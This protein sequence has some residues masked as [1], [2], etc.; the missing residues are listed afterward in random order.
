MESKKRAP[1]ASKPEQLPGLQNGRSRLGQ[2]LSEFAL[3]LPILLLMIF[4][5]IEFAR[6]FQAYLVI[7]NASRFGVRY[8]V[9]GEYDPV[10]CTDGPDSGS[11]AC[12][13]PG[14]TAEEDQARL[15]SIYDVVNGSAVAILKDLGVTD[16]ATAGYFHVTVCSSRPGFN[17]DAASDHCNPMDDPGNPEEGPTRVMVAVTFQ[18][19]MILPFLTT[20]WPTTRLHSERTGILEQFRVARVLGLPPIID[21]PTPT[22]EPPTLTPTFTMT[23]SPTVTPTPTE[24]STP[25]PTFTPTPTSTFTPT[26]VPDC[27]DLQTDSDEPLYLNADDLGIWL[28]NNN[29]VYPAVMTSITT[30]WGGGWHDQVDPVPVNQS[31]DKYTWKGASISNPANVLLT[32]GGSFTHTNLGTIPVSTEGVLGMDFTSSFANVYAYYHGADFS[33][34]LAYTLGGLTCSK[35]VVG[36]LG[37]IVSLEMPPD[38]ITGPFTIRAQASDPDGTVNRVVFEIRDA[39]NNVVFQ[40]TENSAPYCINGDGG[41]GCALVD[42]SAVTWP[43]TSN[44]IVNGTYTLYVQARDNHTHRNYTRVMDTFTINL[45]PTPTPTVTRTPTITLTPTRTPTPTRTLTPSRTPTAG[46]ATP[47]RT[48]TR[49]PTA[50]NSPTVTRTPTITLTPTRTPKATNTSTPTATVP[51]PTRTPTST[52]TPT[53]VVNTRTPTPV[54]T[55]PVPPPTATKTPRTPPPGGG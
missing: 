46:P 53:V 31:F 4:G 41:S 52:K 25:T 21:V 10:Y 51:T 38:P 35:N 9:T 55:T 13:G 14:K 36:R 48:P 40:K 49:T 19:P 24:T 43:G 34:T 28:R 5:I 22:P 3:I 11:G 23:P 44:P 15:Q 1:E 45:A 37:P 26:P 7:V 12:G 39:S 32:P 27:D 50:T 2:A 8:A 6:A 18:H 17:Y 42:P 54:P 16:P 33:V 29:S 20:I 30:S 47:T